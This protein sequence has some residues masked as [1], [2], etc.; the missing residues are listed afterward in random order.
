MGLRDTTGIII[1]EESKTALYYTIRILQDY[2]KEGLIPDN[3][4][5]LLPEEIY[6]TI[7]AP[8]TDLIQMY[9]DAQYCIIEEEKSKPFSKIVWYDFLELIKL[10][11][12]N[13]TQKQI[14]TALDF[15]NQ[16]SEQSYLNNINDVVEQQGDVAR[17]L[18]ERWMYSRNKPT[19]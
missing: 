19:V 10:G 13:L 8:I 2:Y 15:F 7:N 5:R 14:T 11:H 9:N 3:E 18:T 1:F 16:P 6:I 17:R 4:L 12:F